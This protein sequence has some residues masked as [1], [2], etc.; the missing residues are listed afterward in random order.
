MFNLWDGSDFKTTLG[1]KVITEEEGQKS[2]D[3]T[4]KKLSFK[5]EGKGWKAIVA[6]LS[7]CGVDLPD[8]RVDQGIYPEDIEVSL[9]VRCKKRRDQMEGGTPFLDPIAN[10]F[11]H[12][13]HLPFDLTMRDGSLVKGDDFKVAQLHSVLCDEGIPDTTNIFKKMCSWLEKIIQTGTV[14]SDAS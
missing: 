4:A 5:P 3:K 7:D 9:E 1:G 2:A 11:R 10:A 6:M 14:L 13:E 12:M 8:V